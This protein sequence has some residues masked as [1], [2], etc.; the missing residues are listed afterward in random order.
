MNENNNLKTKDSPIS[1]IV[2]TF[3]HEAYIGNMVKNLFEHS[4][5]CIDEV[6]VCDMGSKDDTMYFAL[7]AGAKI[8]T[9][10]TNSMV[11][12]LNHGAAFAT[13]KLLLFLHPQ[14][15]VPK[16]FAQDIIAATENGYDLGC[17]KLTFL[18]KQLPN[19]LQSYMS[20][21]YQTWCRNFH[22]GMFIKKEVFDALDGFSYSR[23]QYALWHL[24]LSAA[25]KKYKFGIFNA[26]AQFSQI[27][28]ATKLPSIAKLYKSYKAQ[29][30]NKPLPTMTFLDKFYLF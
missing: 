8:L 21:S 19:I 23:D 14:T 30:E 29:R 25:S 10:D 16:S 9:P 20:M 22:Q 5:Q 6:I 4:H 7:Q 13:G 11:D 3:N 15:I 27:Q 28:N 2:P 17:Y 18:S 26:T 1:V 24:Y 12:L